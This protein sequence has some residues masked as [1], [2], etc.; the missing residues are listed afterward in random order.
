MKLKSTLI[1]LISV[2][3]IAIIGILLYVYWPAIT[4]TIN[5]SKY[6]TAE[7]GQE[8]YDKGY[9]DGYKNKEENTE[10][11]DYYKSLVDGYYI[12]I[13]NYETEILRLQQS[14]YDSSV[15][16]ESLQSQKASLQN[17]VATLT[18]ANSNNSSTINQLNLM[19]DTLESE[20]ETL[21]NSNENKT[22]QISSLN[23]QILSL[24][25]VITQLQ[26]T[27]TLNANTITALNAQITGLNTQI[28]SLSLQVNNNNSVTSVLQNRITELE[29]SISYYETYMASLSTNDQVI[30][31][32]EFDGS[33]YNVQIIQKNSIV[34]VN[35]PTS[36]NYVIF[37]GWTVNNSLI[38][39]SSYTFSQNTK[40]IADVT[41]K[42]QVKFNVDGTDIATQYVV[43]GSYATLPTA[44]TKANYVFDGWTINGVDVINIGST[45]ITSD[46]I[47]VAK[48]SRLYSVSFIYETNTLS[49]QNVVNGNYATAPSVT[50]STY[51]VF[52][53]WT[54]NNTIVDVSTYHI[55][56][57][58]TFVASITYYYDVTFVVDNVSYS[59]AIVQ[60][61]NCAISPTAPT[62]A[63]YTFNGWTLNGSDV[64]NLQNTVISA[65]TTFYA[66]FTI[67]HYTIT[68]VV[69][70]ITYDTQIIDY[71]SYATLPTA[72][73]KNGYTF[74]GWTVNNTIVNP[75]S[76]SITSNQT[77]VAKFTQ[78]HLIINQTYN[79]SDSGFTEEDIQVSGGFNPK[80][81]RYV[82]LTIY[83]ERITEN[84]VISPVNLS[85]TTSYSYYI[86]SNNDGSWDKD[87][88][89]GEY[90]TQVT[91]IQ[92]SG[93]PV[94]I[95]LIGSYASYQ[96]PKTETYS[97][98]Y[99]VSNGQIVFTIYRPTKSVFSGGV[100]GLVTSADYPYSTFRE[101][102]YSGFVITHLLNC[103]LDFS[104]EF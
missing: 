45:S 99:T 65:N 52:N 93:S 28:S 50:S 15:I 64:V 46:T 36:T 2:A 30:V 100:L 98:Y 89:T 68:F 54:V 66:K 21:S 39:L 57:N 42:H 83:D 32:F 78:T 85:L 86:D 1:S 24:Q 97:V 75:T 5:N 95:T 94:D 11:L 48:F 6:L 77:F 7:Q 51:K 88:D 41:Y 58:T 90:R 91:N 37:N 16:I 19:I 40:V 10:Q 63:N 74:D 22:N 47:F 17:Q 23:N 26:N 92:L 4:G 27:N 87:N 53:G 60:N 49:T 81:E 59:S 3:L 76:V 79:A 101:S 25:N 35:N 43:S 29:N 72:P 34:S 12:T 104:L 20:V 84:S 73:T 61:G 33:V 56:A 13:Q 69:D 71:G 82:R 70:G 67:N 44:P 80:D 14:N 96:N 62:K 38:D 8:L 103:H 18:T 55:T 102:A 31:T 9:N